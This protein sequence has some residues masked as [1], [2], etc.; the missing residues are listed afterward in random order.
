[1]NPVVNVLLSAVL[2][3]GEP[4]SAL[5]LSGGAGV[6]MC[7]G[8]WLVGRPRQKGGQMTGPILTLTHLAP[9][10]DTDR[11]PLLDQPAR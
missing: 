10:F 4:C 1:M 3:S 8:I 6:L 11:L 7:V 9:A 2:G 5:A